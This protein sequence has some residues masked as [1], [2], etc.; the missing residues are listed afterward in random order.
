MSAKFHW[1]QKRC[2]CTQPNW[3]M[4]FWCVPGVNF[5]PE[6]D[7]LDPTQKFSKTNHQSFTEL[8]KNTCKFSL[9]SLLSLTLTWII[10]IWDFLS[11]M[12][13]GREAGKRFQ[14][15]TANFVHILRTCMEV[16]RSNYRCVFVVTT[17]KHLQSISWKFGSFSSIFSSMK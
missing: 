14:S 12:R 7:N 1:D 15:I 2:G 9:T 3:G 6:W 13:F 10:N 16:M 4:V 17:Q 5:F 8:S 11:L